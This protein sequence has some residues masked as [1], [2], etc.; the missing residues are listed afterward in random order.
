MKK[1]IVGLVAVI[2]F[3]IL[4]IFFLLNLL[5]KKETTQLLNTTWIAVEINGKEVNEKV[6]LTNE[7]G[8]VGFTIC[9]HIGYGQIKITQNRL[10]FHPQPQ[11][12]LMACNEP[13]MNLE[14]NF[15]KIFSEPVDYVI[16]NERLIIITEKNTVI[17]VP[18][19]LVS[20]KLE[21]SNRLNILSFNQ[22]V[23]SLE[24]AG[25]RND[26]LTEAFTE[27]ETGI[28]QIDSIQNELSETELVA[29]L[30]DDQS[31]HTNL[32]Y[33]GGDRDTYYQLLPG[34]Y[35]KIFIT[36][37][38]NNLSTNNRECSIIDFTAGESTFKVQDC[39]TSTKNTAINTTITSR[40]QHCYIPLKQ[41]L[42]LAYTQIGNI[43]GDEYDLCSELLNSGLI[44]AT[45][46]EEEIIQPPSELELSRRKAIQ[47]LYPEFT[48]DYEE[49]P[50]FAGCSVK[51]LEDSKDYYY[52]Y[53]SHAS[54]LPVGVAT[55]FKVDPMMRVYKI[56][57]FPDMTDSYIGYNDVD[58][59]TCRGIK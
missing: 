5:S 42:Y 4:A 2:F 50:C 51:S 18:Y 15:I 49:Q 24:F 13:L 40:V 37:T 56:G 32:F 9:N 26:I 22:H 30:Y 48:T 19:N 33:L 38:I 25:Y 21:Y 1:N 8:L 28:S 12:T 34:F 11:S 57:E 52:A 43:I 46:L 6:L 41:N 10:Y 47:D 17:F 54:G 20:N 39:I 31:K 59:K 55:C 53:I 16:E 29:Q 14:S 36:N 27:I 44:G 23:V 58:P 7:Y 45:I 3:S 35:R